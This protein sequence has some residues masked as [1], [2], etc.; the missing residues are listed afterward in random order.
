MILKS[1][2][3]TS[4]YGSGKAFR[5]CRENATGAL[6]MNINEAFEVERERLSVL[7][8]DN[9]IFSA[10]LEI[11]DDPVLSDAIEEHIAGGE[12][13]L[14]AVAS[15]CDDIVSMF[16]SIDDEYLRSRVDDVKDVCR[17]LESRLAGNSSA[18]LDIPDGAV[19]VA[20]E[21]FPSDTS[22][23]DLS[24]V[25][26]FV[27]RKGSITS[28]VCII[29]GTK[30]I[31]VALGVDV[32]KIV[33][34]DYLIVDGD[35]GEVAV[36]PSE[37]ELSKFTKSRIM[38]D[39]EV[40]IIPEPVEYQGHIV[41][42]YGNAGCVEDVEKAMEAGADG[43]GL[44]RTEF[45]FMR[46]EKFPTEDEQFG[47]YRDAALLCGDKP[48]TIRTMDIGGD[49]ALP[50]LD[51]EPEDN[52]FLGVRGI[53]LC[54]ANPDL[55]K[56]Q[57]RA[58]LRAGLYGTVRILVPMVTTSAEIDR[59]REIIEECKAELSAEGKEFDSTIPL[60]AMVET[61]ASVFAGG[62]IAKK[63][64]FFSIGTN[65]LTQ[66]IMAA[67]RGNSGVSMFYNHRDIA[68]KNALTVVV[69]N[70]HK[71]GIKAGIC[72]EAASDPEFAEFLLEIGIDSLSISTPRMIP[73]I[74]GLVRK[75]NP[76]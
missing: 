47:I 3:S 5:L 8:R 44:F 69:A 31:P 10:H 1:G 59:V 13:P 52:P 6:V 48:I 25:S 2:A 67:D 23:M 11:L 42:V 18:S 33:E 34:G 74:K 55:F 73:V 21:I 7:S 65:D 64:D 54:L 40:E 62:S 20:D 50:Y 68:V 26:A 19:V 30:G 28:H 56:I 32:D 49:K 51:M 75:Y 61:P 24:K 15:A 45:V 72:G 43:I 39:R 63:V 22:R 70:A 29:A 41:N 57:L 38:N 46:S 9:D 53:R 71:A 14:D 16:S 12:N 4:G 27:T 66:F 35:A 36:N 76:K 37:D 17:N 60:G 58:I